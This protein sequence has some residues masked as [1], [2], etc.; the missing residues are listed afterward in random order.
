MPDAPSSQLNPEMRSELM[1][2][3]QQLINQYM[4]MNIQLLNQKLENLEK[5][6]QEEKSKLTKEEKDEKDEKKNLKKT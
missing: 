1:T 5:E 3:Q 4:H 6:A 2:Q